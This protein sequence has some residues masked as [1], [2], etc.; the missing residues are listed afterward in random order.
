MSEERA[1]LQ[2]QIE[3]LQR[4]LNEAEQ[5][6]Q[7]IDSRSSLTGRNPQVRIGKTVAATSGGGYPTADSGATAFGV[8]FHDSDFV[9]IEGP[10]SLIG[11]FQSDEVQRIAMTIPP[12][13]IDEGT[14]V[15]VVESDGKH[16]IV[17][18]TGG[19]ESKPVDPPTTEPACDICD[20]IQ[21]LEDFGV[22]SE[23]DAANLRALCDCEVLNECESCIGG[24]MPTEMVVIIAGVTN[25]LGSQASDY[26]LN[27]GINPADWFNDIHYIE[28]N[29]C[30]GRKTLRSEPDPPGSPTADLQ[31]GIRLSHSD[32]GW[33]V[34]LDLIVNDGLGQ[35]RIFTQ[36]AGTGAGDI[37]TDGV[38]YGEYKLESPPDVFTE[39]ED[40]WAVNFEDATLLQLFPSPDPLAPPPLHDYGLNYTCSNSSGNV[41]RPV[42]LSISGLLDTA[43]EPQ[44]D[45]WAE[46][47]NGT[48]SFEHRD[49]GA[50][51]YATVCEPAIW[52]QIPDNSKNDP[53]APR[54]PLVIIFR[55][56]DSAST[57]SLEFLDNTRVDD[58]KLVYFQNPANLFPTGSDGKP[59]V[60]SSYA[61]WVLATSDNADLTAWLS[62]GTFNLNP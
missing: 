62:N 44:Y 61:D 52:I 55:P 46:Y 56:G 22:I 58:R 51:G 39:E 47:I 42:S 35:Q 20:I 6:I 28:M 54:G 40:D 29:G 37:P 21:A 9:E 25:N 60:N 31:L 19:G 38:C 45:N 57:L 17:G 8:I 23:S 30:S 7:A 41:M 15:L 34:R 18:V 27:R 24:D 13:Y 59:L 53:S 49:G 43:T 5:T 48:H 2:R 1:K 4:R 10:N 50:N 36:E 32:D 3:D 26:F 33:V 14:S 12:S 11:A 16:Y